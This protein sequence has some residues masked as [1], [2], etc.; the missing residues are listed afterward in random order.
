MVEPQTPKQTQKNNTDTPA[1][2]NTTT[3]THLVWP[4]TTQNTKKHQHRHDHMCVCE[5][6]VCVPTWFGNGLRGVI[7][8]NAA[9]KGNLVHRRRQGGGFYWARMAKTGC[10]KKMQQHK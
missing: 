10:K 3:R 8:Q 7:E 2:T 1:N 4:T 9:K 5:G 6:D